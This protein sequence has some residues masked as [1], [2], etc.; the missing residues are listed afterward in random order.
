MV[1]KARSEVKSNAVADAAASSSSGRDAAIATAIDS[2]PKG[3]AA[4][5]REHRSSRGTAAATDITRPEGTTRSRPLKQP[6]KQSRCR[7]PACK[8]DGT[9]KT[10][11][12]ALEAVLQPLHP[13]AAA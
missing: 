6:W 3:G 8:R 5:S 13:P 11:A 7:Q 10:S 4:Q 12:A 2:T 9:V 1:V